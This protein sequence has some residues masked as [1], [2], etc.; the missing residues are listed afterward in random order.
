MGKR[1]S[2]VNKFY[3]P[4]S[5]SSVSSSPFKKTSTTPILPSVPTFGSP[6]KHAPNPPAPPPPPPRPYSRYSRS[7]VF[8]APHQLSPLETK[9][10]ITQNVHFVKTC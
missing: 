8:R 5:N 4:S 1:S 7:R 9:G 3:S 10:I 6:I 2:F